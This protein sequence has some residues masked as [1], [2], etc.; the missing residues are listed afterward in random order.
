MLS[1]YTFVTPVLGIF[2]DIQKL[3][4]GSYLYLFWTGLEKIFKVGILS[5]VTVEAIPGH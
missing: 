1:K 5:R 4:L 2:S 3:A